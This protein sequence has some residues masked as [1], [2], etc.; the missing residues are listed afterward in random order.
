M[1]CV[2]KRLFH[3]YLFLNTN[4]MNDLKVHWFALSSKVRNVI[5]QKIIRIYSYVNYLIKNSFSKFKT[6]VN[7]TTLEISN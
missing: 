1:R 3:A 5:L 6:K 4:N 2:L 7:I